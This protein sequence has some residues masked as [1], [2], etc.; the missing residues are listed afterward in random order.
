MRSLIALTVALCVGGAVSAFDSREVS[1]RNEPAGISLAGTLTCPASGGHPRGALVLATGSGIQDRDETVFGHKPFKVIAEG[2]SD[3]GFAVLRMDDRGAGGSEGDPQSATTDDFVTDIRAGVAYLDSIF[4]NIPVGVLGHSEGGLIAVREAVYDPRVDFI[5]TMGCPAVAGDSLILMQM[6]ALNR[7]AT[8][9]DEAFA[10]AY[11]MQRQ[12]LDLVKSQ[13]I[14]P[15]K[16]ARMSMVFAERMPAEY[17][18]PQVRQ[19]IDNQIDAMLSPWYVAFVRYD[20]SGDIAAVSKPW[21]A[22][23]GSLDLQVP[24]GNIEV[25]ARNTKAT[26]RVLDCHNHLMQRCSSGLPEEY[27]NIAEDIDPEVVSIIVKWLDDICR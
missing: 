4:A 13:L 12:L 23:N 27:G 9:G 17:A 21:L 10:K 1:V 22:L 7:V 20:L 11:P 16:R 15:L 24:V 19:H 8:G 26:V 6:R 25:I 18:V 14:T 5:V 2:L 3:A